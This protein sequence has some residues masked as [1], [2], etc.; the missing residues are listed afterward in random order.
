M[1][2]GTD[3]ERRANDA[4]TLVGR[5]LRAVALLLET[6]PPLTLEDAVRATGLP[7]RSVMRRIED[8]R[9]AG[10]SI[11]AARIGGGKVGW[12]L[13]GSDAEA[14]AAASAARRDT[15]VVPETKS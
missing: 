10:V 15:V 9:D 13:A 11:G 7:A 12:V 1:S 3:I 8:L 4:A 2:G 6:A 14:M 5:Q